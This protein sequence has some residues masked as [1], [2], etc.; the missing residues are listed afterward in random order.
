[1]T[2][3]SS[4]LAGH[5][6]KRH[7][8]IESFHLAHLRL[9]RHL[10][11]DRVDLSAD[12][13]EPSWQTILSWASIFMQSDAD[14]HVELALMGAVSALLTASLDSDRTRD[15]AAFVLESGSNMRTVVLAL[16]QGMLSEQLYATNRIPAVIRRHQR[17][18]QHFIY[19]DIHGVTIPV[20]NFQERTWNALEKKQDTALSAPT[21]AG[22]SFILLLWL[23][24]SLYEAQKSEVYA[25][26]VPSRA[27]INQVSRD[28]AEACIT[29]NLR[30]Q[31]ATM[32]TLFAE[33]PGR[34]AVLVM[35]Q[36]RLERL[37]ADNDSLQL[38][39]LV[40]DEAQKLGE[41]ERGVVLQRVIDEALRR[42]NQCR[43]V[44]AA[45]HANNASVL[46]PRLQRSAS[47]DR[48]EAVIAD[49]R[50][51]VLQN[52]LWVTP[53]PRRS[54]RWKVEL[55]QE[56]EPRPVG[57]LRVPGKPTGKKKKLA[58]L[59]FSLGHG[60]VG[61]IVFANGPAEAEEI[62]QL[63]RE[64]FVLHQTLSASDPEITDLVRLIRDYVHPSYPLV[65]T[66]I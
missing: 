14:E 43:V 42:S 2:S 58:A 9:V 61:N 41:G 17:R 60:N 52:L 29:N 1:M 28:I 44:L 37:F 38:K 32:P 24:R 11:K 59:A 23:V 50:P 22:K 21:S 36:E 13:E 18:L 31:I 3:L 16:A 51:T 10:L 27:L 65:E 55:I 56:N 53:I 46:L 49:G 47:D 12:E 39:A 19:D 26:L 64:H 25:Y 8:V 48:V 30:P 20:T 33:T 40:V 63:L 4:R 45:P 5:L 57:E 66:E 6:C 15:A 7:S 54:A 62:A 34:S 35:T